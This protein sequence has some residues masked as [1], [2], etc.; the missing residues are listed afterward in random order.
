MGFS[1]SKSNVHGH[2]AANEM[3]LPPTLGNPVRDQSVGK[4]GQL[5]TLGFRF[6][7]SPQNLVKMCSFR[8]GL[9]IA[10]L[11]INLHGFRGKLIARFR[12]SCK[13]G[14][15]SVSL[16][17]C[18]TSLIHGSHLCLDCSWKVIIHDNNSADD[19]TSA[20]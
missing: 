4:A 20:S 18:I 19:E 13:S 6:R 9:G 15:G 2:F 17:A 3:N 12:R 5:P 16:A 10:R 14:S 7:F 1:R 8:Y 11:Q